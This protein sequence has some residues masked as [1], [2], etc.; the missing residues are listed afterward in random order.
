MDAVLVKALLLLIALCPTA[1]A[2]PWKTYR[3]AGLGIV[4]QYP[5]DW[6]PAWHEEKQI[7]TV[8]PDRERPPYIA[9][10]TRPNNPR[11]LTVEKWYRTT[12]RQEAGAHAGQFAGLPAM[13]IPSTRKD[14]QYLVYQMARP[15]GQIFM[16]AS[17]H[18]PTDSTA[19]PTL[20]KILASFRFSK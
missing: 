11:N 15:G 4:F 20:E 13:V 2:E 9:F 19:K 3:D 17:R 5:P 7:L 8:M 1:W 14:A 16:V 18:L 10:Q 6:K 12:Q